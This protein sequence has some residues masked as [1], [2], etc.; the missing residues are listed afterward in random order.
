LDH[1]IHSDI[2]ATA[3]R[4]SQETEAELEKRNNADCRYFMLD[5]TPGFRTTGVGVGLLVEW[6]NFRPPWHDGAFEERWAAIIDTR[7]KEAFVL[8]RAAEDHN[9]CLLS[10]IIR[11]YEIQPRSVSL[12]ASE[13][14]MKALLGRLVGDEEMEGA[15]E[16]LGLDSEK[17]FFQV[18][19]YDGTSDI[20]CGGMISG[21]R[22]RMCVAWSSINEI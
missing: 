18:E 13:K 9:A 21:L 16:F 22:E 14:R 4:L 2:M 19:H 17:Q 10:A 8:W 5:H 6:P 7:T 20:E 12:V 11:V 3:R 1:I 15:Q